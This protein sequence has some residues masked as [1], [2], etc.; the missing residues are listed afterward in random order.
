MLPRHGA[1]LHHAA[2]SCRS[3]K[4]P[5]D[6]PIQYLEKCDLSVNEDTAKAIGITIPENL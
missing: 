4:K 6:M 5:A 1:A 2:A 3:G